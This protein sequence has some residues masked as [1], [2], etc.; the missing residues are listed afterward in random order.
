MIC[1]C[2]AG[3]W[4]EATATDTATIKP[5]RISPEPGFINEAISEVVLEFPEGITS[6]KF[7]DTALLYYDPSEGV[8]KAGRIFFGG[9]EIDQSPDMYS[10]STEGAR[11]VF[12]PKKVWDI[13]GKYQLMI[14]AGALIFTRSDGTMFENGNMIHFIWE[15]GILPNP[16]VKPAAGDVEDLSTFS[17]C[18]PEGFLFVAGY[19]LMDRFMPTVYR[20]DA[21]GEKLEYAGR[22]TQLLNA[23]TWKNSNEVTYGE[24]NF[25]PEE[26][27]YYL[28]SILPGILYLQDEEAKSEAKPILAFSVL[29]RYTGNGESTGIENMGA[30]GVELAIYNIAGQRLRVKSVS[31]L[32]K[33][34]YIVNGRKMIVR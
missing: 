10:A 15:L 23:T 9:D 29:Y 34:I 26:G 11:V 19:P 24:P 12:T 22:Y 8:D 1:V 28:V 14:P 17:I 31:E 21:M 6:V 27:E 7:S 33:G 16:T 30:E 18:M 32:A 2:I 3:V 5:E 25:E 20:S 13:Y 4:A